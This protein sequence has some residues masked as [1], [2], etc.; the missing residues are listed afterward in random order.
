MVQAVCHIGADCCEDAHTEALLGQRWYGLLSTASVQDH[1]RGGP[2][3]AVYGER[4]QTGCHAR[5]AVAAYEL[6]R[7]AV[8]D[9]RSDD[10]DHGLHIVDEGLQGAIGMVISLVTAARDRSGA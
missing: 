3:E 6:V 5:L 4:H 7:V 9:D 8:G 10:A 1:H 2:D